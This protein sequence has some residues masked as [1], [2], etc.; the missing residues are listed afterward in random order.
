MEEVM[1][2]PFFSLI[3]LMTVLGIPAFTLVQ[4]NPAPAAVSAPVPTPTVDLKNAP[5]I[6]FNKTTHNF[7]EVVE[8]PDI[9]H[10]FYFYNRGNS[11]LHINNVGTSCGCTGAVLGGKNDISP[12]EK[13]TIKVTYHTQGRPG[14]ATKIITVSSNDPVDPN[15][16]L[17]IDMTVVREVELQPDRLYFYAVK[18]H[19]KQTSNV[20]VLGRAGKSLTVLSAQSVSQ[21]VAVTSLK[22]YKDEQQKDEQQKRNGAEIEITVPDTMPIT[23]FN[24]EIV[25]KTDNAKKP[26]LR[27]PVTGEVVGRVV[28][29][30]KN[31][32]FSARQ[33]YPVTVT[34]TVSE[35]PADFAIRRVESAKNLVR[36]YVKKSTGS[37]G[38]DQWYLVTSVIK[39][40]PKDSDGKDQIAV[41]SNDPIQKVIIITV[42]T[43]K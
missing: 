40:I 38:V 37:D 20:K 27:L 10:N 9:T 36:P 15:F 5:R 2:Y 31:I 11:I 1:K 33:D 35:K 21:V 43:N 41:Y 14:H 19:N 24:D 8:G 25:I 34:F 6:H 29:N 4:A 28:Y 12:G 32:T 23:T 13:A 22:P 17:K 30:P 7:R 39:N 26:E 18:Y 42:E 16:Q 3:T